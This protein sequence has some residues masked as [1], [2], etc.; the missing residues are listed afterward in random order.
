MSE[1]AGAKRIHLMGIGGAGMS[2]LARLLSSMGNAVSGC[3]LRHE[4]SYIKALEA[5]GVSCMA[6]HSREHLER[7]DP[8]LVIF[9]SAVDGNCEELVAA[10][11][12]GIRTVG[13][14]EALS[15]LFNEARGV[16]VAGTHGKTTTTSMIGLVL[17]RAG[18]SPTLYIGAEVQDIGTNA[19]LGGNPLFVA[20][21]DESDG[22]FEYFH[23]SL[24]VVTNI[25][26][27]HV[28]HFG[29]REDVVEAFVRFAGGLKP[30]ASLVACA[31]DEGVQAMMKKTQG[32]KAQGPFLRH[33]PGGGVS[34]AVCRRGEDLGRLEMSVSGEHNVLNALAA[35]AASDALGV[36]FRTAADTLRT[37][38]GAA[39]RLQTLGVRN[40]VLVIDDYAHHPAEIAAS[41]G[42][43]R[44]VHAGRRLVV[45]F[46]PHRYSRTAAFLGPLAAA[47]READLVLLLPVYGAGEAVVPSVSS[48]GIADRLRAEGRPCRLCE[49]EADALSALGSL[50]RDG[51]VLLTLGAGSVSRLGGLFLSG[52]GT[53]AEGECAVPLPIEGLE[54]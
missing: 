31:E 13:R 35:L 44:R 14:G 50:L 23:P 46:Q 6:G 15:W 49:G 3:D 39:R 32:S 8:Q 52:E 30:G 7:F 18:L 47:L 17:E 40:G 43:M 10:R 36:P 25:D 27:D 16:G 12:E 20:E 42:A 29:S 45:V 34:F 4:S 1:L 41:L 51:D 33:K 11:C 24:A 26:W 28:D 38:R 9:S 37:F 19:R 22:S 21:L 54:L 5:L 48:R 2:S 53:G